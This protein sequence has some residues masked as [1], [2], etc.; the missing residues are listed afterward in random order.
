MN[1]IGFCLWPHLWAREARNALHIHQQHE[2][3]QNTMS[4][5]FLRQKHEWEFV[6]DEWDILRR[7]TEYSESLLKQV[8]IVALDMRCTRD[9]KG[10][11]HPC[12]RSLHTY[13][14]TESWE[15]CRLWWN[16]TW[17]TQCLQQMSFSVDSCVSSGMA[18][19]KET[20]S[21]RCFVCS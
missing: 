2:T 3:L 8:T 5:H 10:R 11:C 16:R 15:G 20:D 7:W 21:H 12:S 14:N 17:N 4:F 13:Q 9:R 19:W 1:A 6:F 18:F